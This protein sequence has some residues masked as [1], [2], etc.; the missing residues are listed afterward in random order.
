MTQDRI[1]IPL[2]DAEFAT[3]MKEFDSSG[4]WMREQLTLNRAA[5]THN[6]LNQSRVDAAVGGRRVDPGQPYKP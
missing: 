2:S 3:M 4:E 1:A 6:V 5:S